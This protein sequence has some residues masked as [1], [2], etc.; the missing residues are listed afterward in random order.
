MKTAIYTRISDDKQ[1][2]GAGVER[3][4]KEC[5]DLANREGW[6]VVSVCSDNSISAYTRKRRP[7]FDEL[8]DLI[9]GGEVDA[10]VTWAADRLTRHP[11]ELEDL[12]D[13]L[14]ETGTS[15]KT[16]MSGDYDLT[17]ADGRAH[18]R[19]VGAIARQESEKK[20]E[21]IKSQKAQATSQGKRP[22]GR[23]A[24]GW[25][26]GRADV[27]PEEIAIIRE[28]ANRV[29]AGE[30]ISTI[31]NDLTARGVR[32]ATGNSEW[33]RRSVRQMLRNPATA[34]LRA[35]ADGGVVV[36]EW[37]GAYSRDTWN[38]LCAVLD[39][40]KRKTTHRI[41]S[42]LLVGLVYDQEGRRLA[43]RHYQKTG[44][45]GH[46]LYATPPRSKGRPGVTIRASLVEEVVTEAVLQLTDTLEIPAPVAD[47]ATSDD[48][49]AIEAQLEDLASQYGRGEVTAGE[50]QAAKAPLRI[51]LAEARAAE[52]K[53]PPLVSMDWAKPGLLRTSWDELTIHQKR[54]ALEL[55][56]DRVEIAPGDIGANGPH[57]ERIS[58]TWKA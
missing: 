10:I 32:T 21:R 14:N 36:G 23:R 5:R 16:V 1:G 28:V 35:Q 2:T 56:I 34:G 46:R 6:E 30:G 25:T 27:V 44:R 57:P 45:P 52:R 8:T 13:L 11:R 17:S 31:T 51:R 33:H 18:A 9:R 53:A 26:S 43:S 24:Y 3:Q 29:L 19:I 50:W 4:E 39:D 41:R 54:Q 40:P 20:S 42:Y 55:F 7:G 22:G 58:V 49:A 37:Q 47:A 38:Q 15:V 12:V 48:V